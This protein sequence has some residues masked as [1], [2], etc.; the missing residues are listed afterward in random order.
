M[1]EAETDYI[2]LR[3]FIVKWEGYSATPYVNSGLWH[4]GI[5]HVFRDQ[6]P[7]NI[8]D[9]Y[10][11]SEIDAFFR[12]DVCIAGDVARRLFASFE[13]QPQSVQFLLIDLAF[14]LGETGLSKFVK[15]RA[16]MDAFN[17]H[18]AAKELIDSI[19]YRQVGKR[20]KHHVHFLNSLANLPN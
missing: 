8:K 4:I 20:S 13:T 11:D 7:A 12:S 16:A 18:N 1:I 6:N 3:E 5:G 9:T 15:F 19:W 14:N 10:S 17:Y 2:A